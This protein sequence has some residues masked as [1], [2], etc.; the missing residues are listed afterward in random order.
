[1]SQLFSP[2]TLRSVT[3]PNR[4][5]A[6]PMCMYMAK[7][8]VS[9][10]FHLS[11][12]SALARGGAGLIFTEATAIE[13]RGRISHGCCGLWS[14]EQ[15]EAYR[16]VTQ[17][18]AAAGAVPAIQIA[19]AG[20]KASAHAAFDGGHALQPA[21]AKRGL[22]LWPTIAPSALAMT[23]GAP[24][25]HALSESE[26]AETVDLF[27]QATRRAV[28]AGFRVLEVHAAHGYLIHSFLSPLSNKRND[29]YGGELNGRMRYALEVA[30]A[31][32][33]AWPEELPLFFRISSIDGP[34]DG[35]KIEDSAALAIELKARGVDVIDCSSGG[36][37]GAARYRA[38][39]NGKP[40][41]S[42]GERPRG[43]QVP[44]AEHIRKH[45]DIRTMAVGVIVDPHQAEDIIA[46]GRA[47]L[48]ALGRELLYNPFWPLHAAQSLD[49][50]P[51]FR[52]WPNSYRWAVNRRAE[53]LGSQPNQDQRRQS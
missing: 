21:D 47:D 4:V 43:F 41:S 35:W 12:L 16:P 23:E 37:S 40:L 34:A 11:H 50:D 17:A 52:L 25:P 30:E 24:V 39:D 27:A 19:H 1:M 10:D 6:S 28:R 46:S 48:V 22:I 42:A 7:D 13:P 36:I 26:I 44:Y 18:I 29:A 32:R 9:N 31:V 49:I 53:I 33:A 8:G 14:E 38:T 45:A 3:L 51:Q 5:A 20:R 2:L 15:I